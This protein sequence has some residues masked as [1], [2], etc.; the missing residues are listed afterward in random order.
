MN[1]RGFI[2]RLA[3]IGVML[4]TEQRATKAVAPVIF[5]DIPG[6]N[7]ISYRGLQFDGYQVFQSV[8]LR[9]EQA[10]E[11]EGRVFMHPS[12]FALLAAGRLT[13]T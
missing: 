6:P 1:R 8:Y 12:K 5:V 2:A 13:Y 9:P 3:A 4:C 10:V 7:G 11:S